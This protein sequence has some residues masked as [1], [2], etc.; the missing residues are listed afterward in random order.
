MG[1]PFQ[2]PAPDQLVPHFIVPVAGSVQAS[3]LPSSGRCWP[4]GASAG[5]G[6]GAG[7]GTALFVV[8][9]GL[10]YFR[11]RLLR[12]GHASGHDPQLRYKTTKSQPFELRGTMSPHE[13]AHD[14]RPEELQA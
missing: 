7:L 11:S 3:P 4:A 9:A 2:A 12:Q 14:V 10:W 6:V 1:E 8:S 5:I 13:L